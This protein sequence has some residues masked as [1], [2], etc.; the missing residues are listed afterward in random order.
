MGQLIVNKCLVVT[1]TWERGQILCFPGLPG[2]PILPASRKMS[3]EGFC[4]GGR[5]TCHGGRIWTPSSLSMEQ[6]LVIIAN[7]MRVVNSC[8][9][10]HRFIGLRWYQLTEIK[11]GTILTRNVYIYGKT[12]VCVHIYFECFYERYLRS[13]HYGYIF[14]EVISFSLKLIF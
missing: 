9:F 10:L 3:L 12:R 4:N 8:G 2:T 6:S 14:I 5:H 11:Q 7:T 13:L 1:L